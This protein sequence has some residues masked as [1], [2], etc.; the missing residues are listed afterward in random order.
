MIWETVVPVENMGA[1]NG[2]NGFQNPATKKV[3]SVVGHSPLN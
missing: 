3:V 2:K 1:R